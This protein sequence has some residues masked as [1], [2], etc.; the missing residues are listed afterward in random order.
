MNQTRITI[1][2]LWCL[3]QIPI[4][5]YAIPCGQIRRFTLKEGGR[6]SPFFPWCSEAD[7]LFGSAARRRSILECSPPSP[8]RACLSIRKHNHSTPTRD[9][10]RHVRALARNHPLGPLGFDPPNIAQRHALPERW[11]LQG[12][13]SPITTK[14]LTYRIGLDDGATSVSSR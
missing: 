11:K 12:H 5:Y 8:F 13:V 6:D 1:L 3:L 2:V 9:I 4:L 7:P 14:Y 10:K